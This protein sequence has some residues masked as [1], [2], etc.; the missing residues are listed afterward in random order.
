M[1]QF[2]E[3]MPIAILKKFNPVPKL[4]IS[5]CFFWFYNMYGIQTR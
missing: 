5:A 4:D 1:L 3:S 2:N